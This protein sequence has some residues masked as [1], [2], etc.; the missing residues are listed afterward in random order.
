[1]PSQLQDRFAPTQQRSRDTAARLQQAALALMA[2]GGLKACTIPAIAERAGVAVGTVYRRYPDKNTLLTEAVLAMYASLA[3]GRAGEIERLVT[4]AEDLHGFFRNLAL[5]MIGT[6]VASQTMLK[7]LR[8]LVDL[9]ADAT[10]R[11][12]F[13]QRYGEP[14]ALLRRLAW[15]RFQR[16]IVAGED[17][18]THAI[19]VTLG[20]IQ[21][22]YANKLSSNSEP[23]TD[24]EIFAQELARMQAAYLGSA[25]DRGL[26]TK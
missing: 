9:T 4:S 26:A 22:M 5:T 7:A 15:A 20:S 13:A 14:R 2:E 21:A 1:M 24:P 19:N 25:R 23:A 12:E 17:A 16:E 11:D 6:T 8:E 18:L 10:F 3:S